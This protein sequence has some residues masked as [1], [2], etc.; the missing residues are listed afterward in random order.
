MKIVSLLIVL[1]TAVIGFCFSQQ[2]GFRGD[3]N[4]L[5]DRLIVSELV[6]FD[7]IFQQVGING[8]PGIVA[9]PF[10]E[11]SNPMPIPQLVLDGLLKGKLLAYDA[12][13]QDELFPYSIFEKSR[14][15]STEQIRRNLGE[16]VDTVLT[17][18]ENGAEIKLLVKYDFV[19]EEL[20]LLNFIEAWKYSE[21]PP[22]FEKEVIA[23]EPVRRY[24]FGDSENEEFRYQKAFRIYNPE[25]TEKTHG[26]LKLAAQISYEYFF[27]L[28]N[29]FL[30][31]Y[32]PQAVLQYFE[33][34]ASNFDMGLSFGSQNAP[35]FNTFSQKTFVKSLVN[36]AMSGK[37]TIKE[38]NTQVVLTKKQVHDAIYREKIIYMADLEG[39]MIEKKVNQDVSEDINSVVFIEDWF[40]DPQ[41]MRIEKKVKGIAPV[42]YYMDYTSP[43]DPV[44]M[45]EI[46]FT[47]Y[48]N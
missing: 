4:L 3:N 2:T 29:I 30:M 42:R 10:F 36:I 40:F 12:Q 20:A 6:G 27:N 17:Q 44:L 18:D 32:F 9:K 33:K 28:G 37:A 21:D 24:S 5:P 22:V 19:P 23:Y 26:N 14:Q 31:E 8:K 39:N 16:R 48:F 15:L 1:K 25:S 13:N 11:I 47:I 38:Y 46:L 41:T 45:R 35:F 43:D 7:T 34:S